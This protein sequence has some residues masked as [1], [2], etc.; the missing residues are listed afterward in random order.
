MIIMAA[1]YSEEVARLVNIE[2]KMVK[3]VAILKEN[4]LELLIN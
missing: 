3:E 4:G 2:F 1:G